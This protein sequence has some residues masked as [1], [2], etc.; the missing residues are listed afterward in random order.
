MVFTHFSRS[1]KEQELNFI[2]EIPLRRHQRIFL[3]LG[4]VRL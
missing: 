2:C 3:L 4:S 1:F